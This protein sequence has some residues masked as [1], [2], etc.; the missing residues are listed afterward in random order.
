[1]NNKVLMCIPSVTLR[2]YIL[3][4]PISLSRMQEATIVAEFGSIEEKPVLLK[5]LADLSDNETEKALFLS[6]RDDFQMYGY[7]DEKT[8]Q[9]YRDSELSKQGCNPRYPFEEYCGLPVLYH[10]GDVI[11][12]DSSNYV[13]EYTPFSNGSASEFVGECYLCYPLDKVYKCKKDLYAAHEHF[14]VCTVEAP[15]EVPLTD[16]QKQSLE[17]VRRILNI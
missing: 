9:I 2:S 4:H 11:S 10:V 5:E 8:N 16:L 15:S 1:M 12:H 17:S 7:I 14:H 13:I 6:A 3:S